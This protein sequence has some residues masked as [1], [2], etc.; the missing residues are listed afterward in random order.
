[1]QFN[2]LQLTKLQENVAASLRPVL[3][4]L[5]LDGRFISGQAI[6]TATTQVEHKLGRTPTGYII[7]DQ[8]AAASVF[9][10]SKDDKFLTLDTSANVTVSLWVF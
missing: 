1:M 2:D 8:S 5:F 10:V 9:T 7:L 3:A 4:V 6:T